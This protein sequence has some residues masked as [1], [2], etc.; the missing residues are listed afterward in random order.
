MGDSLFVT[1]VNGNPV[2]GADV[3]LFGSYGSLL[4]DYAGTWGYQL[5]GAG[6]DALAQG[7]S[8]DDVFGYTIADASGA[9]ASST[10]TI[11]ITDAGDCIL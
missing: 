9:T 11:H 2:D 4:I 6:T 3:Y 7:T 8:V 5:N 1:E 10:L